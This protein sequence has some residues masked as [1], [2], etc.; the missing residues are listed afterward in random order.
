VD[1][2]ENHVDLGHHLAIAEPQNPKSLFF[3]IAGPLGVV[4]DGF[5]ESM[6]ISIDFDDQPD[7]QTAKSATYGPIATCRRKWERSSGS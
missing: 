4:S 1:R 5:I 2:I 3:E 6:L 7:R